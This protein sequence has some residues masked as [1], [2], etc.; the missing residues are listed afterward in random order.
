MPNDTDQPR[1]MLAQI[2]WASWWNEGERIRF[3]KNQG[4]EDFLKH[5][6]LR[7]VVEWIEPEKLDY[8]LHNAAYDLQ[9]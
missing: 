5:D 8:T 3:P 9:K 4:V 1:P 7:T 2:H 6:R